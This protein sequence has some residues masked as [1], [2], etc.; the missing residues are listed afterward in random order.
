MNA[1]ESANPSLTQLF[2]MNATEFASVTHDGL[3]D[4]AFPIRWPHRTTAP[5]RPRGSTGGA[6]HQSEPAPRLPGALLPTV[7]GGG[8]VAPAPPQN[9]AQMCTLKGCGVHASGVVVAAHERR[10]LHRASSGTGVWGTGVGDEWQQ[11]TIYSGS[12]V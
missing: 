3:S 1:P 4:S 8:G 6:V 7:W 5:L 11:R 10:D 12:L 2:E 9:F